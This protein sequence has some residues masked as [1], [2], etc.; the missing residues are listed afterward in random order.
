MALWRCSTRCVRALSACPDCS[1]DG[2]GKVAAR[3]P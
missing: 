3:E 2:V 1:M